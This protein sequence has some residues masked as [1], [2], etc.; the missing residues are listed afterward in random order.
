MSKAHGKNAFLFVIVT[1]ALD[2]LAFGI[3]IPVVP[4]FLTEITGQSK[5]ETV[6][7]A[8]FLTATFGVV[9]FLMM[10]TLGN[11]SDRFGRRP[12]LLIS[13]SM[14]C[15]DF[16]I[17]GF[18]HSLI[19]LFIGRALAGLTS[20]T[21]STATAY[22]ADVTEPEDRSRAFGMIGA[23]FGFGFVFGP[24]VGGLLGDIDT[25]LP[26]FVSAG[27][28]GLNFL[29]GFF[30]LPES[31]DKENR[32]S[33]E[34]RRSNPFGAFTHFSKIPKIA[35]FLVALSI[36]QLAH[37]VYPGS[38]NFYGAIR[39][40]WDS[41]QIGFSLGVVGIS[42]AIVQALLVGPITKRIGPE[43]A[44][45]VGF[46]IGVAGMFGM[47]FT[48]EG[49][50]AYSVIIGSAL[51]G[52]A[53]PSL[54]TLMTRIT[55]KNA[56]GELQG[57][58]ASLQSLS[59]IIGPVVMTQILHYFTSSSTPVYFAG[60]NFLLAGTLALIAMFPLMLGIR[61]NQNKVQ[62]IVETYSEDTKASA[63]S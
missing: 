22:I 36:F 57:A 33:F 38:W 55:P 59:M 56:Q 21:Y 52:I 14:L 6:A 16:L 31:L 40:G 10:P 35:W 25:R 51:G 39:Y 17:M 53:T 1:V 8:G 13:V 61:S 44:V 63:D 45:Y 50:M 62:E 60:A 47:A 15:I 5:S 34:L 42:S 24:V 27:I 49:W 12:V 26:F 2:L 29:Y 11:L 37:A 19:I 46:G 48:F 41:Q 4:D 43:K 58:V 3:F 54:Q 23:A 28:A 18:A 7:I 9:N 30:V 20:A 32:R